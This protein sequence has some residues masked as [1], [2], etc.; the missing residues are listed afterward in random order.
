MFTAYIDDSGTDPNQKV[1]IAS[2]LVV[3]AKCMIAL[4]NEWEKL[5]R[6]EHF[7]CFHMSP[8]VAS[9]NKKSKETEFKDWDDVKRARVYERVRQITKKYGTWAMS[10][11]VKK[12]AYDDLIPEEIRILTGRFQYSWA[13]RHVLDHLASWRI[14]SA[15]I[16]APLEYVFSWM[17]NDEYKKEIEAVVSQSAIA[18]KQAGYEGE[19]DN[20]SFRKPTLLP[21]LQCV[22]FVARISYRFA[23]HAYFEEELPKEAQI[24]WKDIATHDRGNWFTGITI[25]DSQLR[26]FVE[27]EMRTGHAKN[28]FAQWAE[29]SAKQRVQRAR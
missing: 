29:E 3:P 6:R 2:A 8:F 12:S 17:E 15:T 5:K 19:F 24:G 25:R 9:R 10:L 28:W 22:D 11:A 20:Y 4:D 7:S 27:A 1:A 13:V 18:A 26:K 16:S 23:L 21:G 14:R